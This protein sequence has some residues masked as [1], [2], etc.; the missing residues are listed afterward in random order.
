[1]RSFLLFLPLVLSAQTADSN[2]RVTEA[3]IAEIQQLRLAIERATLLGAR[4][5]LAISQLQIQETALARLNSQLTD[6]RSQASSRE[7]ERMAAAIRDLEARKPAP[8]MEALNEQQINQMK[9]Q[10]EEVTAREQQLAAR[11]GELAAQ[12]QAAQ[13]Q[14]ADSRAR[15]AGLEKTLDTAIQELLKQK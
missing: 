5:Q 12:Y 10:L 7:R 1:M 15:I 11:E 4:T 2:Q 9:L 14:A 8:G 3:L 13:N 6:V